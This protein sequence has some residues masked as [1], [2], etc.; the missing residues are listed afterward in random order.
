[1]I[2]E[3]RELSN[4][5]SIRIKLI[6]IAK[7][8]IPI[9]NF[10]LMRSIDDKIVFLKNS[11]SC[12]FCDL[13]KGN[14][15]GEDLKNV[16]LRYAVLIEADLSNSILSGANLRNANLSGANLS[17]VDLSNQDLT[18]TI[19]TNSNLSRT[20][21]DGIILNNKDLTGVN[22]S[23]VDLRNKRLIGVNLSKV[24]LRH[25]DLTGVNLSGVDLSNQDL[26]GTIL[27]NSNLSGV[28]LDGVDLRDKDLTGV[29]LSGV[30]LSNQDLTGT[31]LNN[32]K[33]VEILIKNPQNLNSSWKN[34]IQNLNITRYDFSKNG[35]FFS[36]KEGSIFEF[37]NNE[38]NLVLD[39]SN[40][41]NTNSFN[42]DGVEAGLLGIASKD[43]LIYLSYTV[44]NNDGVSSLVVDEFSNNFIKV[45]NIIKIDGFNDIHFGGN[46]LFDNLGKL[47]LSVGD[48]YSAD[49][50]QKLNSLKGKILRLD[51][52]QSKLNPE[53]IA[54]GIRNPWGV[55]IDSK[56]RMFVLQ[57]GQY[58]VEAAF[59]L[60]DLYPNEPFNLGWPIY[61][62]SK[63][64]GKDDLLDVLT[65]IFET[66]SRPGCLTAGIYLEDFELFL[67][68]DF[69]GTIR[70]L[71]QNEVGEWY[72]Y[73]EHK[74][75]KFIWSFGFDKKTK[76]I[77]IAPNNLEVEIIVN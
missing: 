64:L 45:R 59:L 30:D 58:Y 39:L 29:N 69:Y 56:N 20:N 41:E 57:C 73:H 27:I 36:T 76:K 12:A 15:N 47:Y 5:P 67:F 4:S 11:G 62:G 37:T 66:Y 34:K 13:T 63:R 44:K 2:N 22:L 53:I 52:T 8:I 32:N 1:L 25:K 46:L 24:D 17:G 54:Y 21:L 51:L 28:N 6:N 55:A 60:D 77:L 75:D 68:A 50:A 33:V 19:L 40:S 16:D 9:K 43:D 26:T 3:V 71:K 61:E 49:E 35:N 23:G 70:L 18:G 65:P 31:I 72:L 14:L 42:S 38:L 48:G 74:Q 7:V 10:I